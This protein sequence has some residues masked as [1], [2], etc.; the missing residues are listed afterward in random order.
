MDERKYQ[1]KKEKQ[2]CGIRKKFAAKF[3]TPSH[4]VVEYTSEQIRN[5]VDDRQCPLGYG[6]M[7]NLD[8]DGGPD[9]AHNT[10]QVFEGHVRASTQES[11]SATPF[12]WSESE[13][14]SPLE[15]SVERRLLNILHAGLSF[16]GNTKAIDMTD[17]RKGYYDLQELKN[18]LE[19]R[20]AHWD[21]DDSHADHIPQQSAHSGQLNQ[22]AELMAEERSTGSLDAV[23]PANLPSNC[24][25]FLHRQ[26]PLGNTSRR[27]QSFRGGGGTVSLYT[28]YEG[29]QTEQLH[30]DLEIEAENMEAD[31]EF[32]RKLDEAFHEIM[33]S[34]SKRLEPTKERIEAQ[35]S[36]SQSSLNMGDEPWRSLPITDLLQRE[37]LPTLLYDQLGFDIPCLSPNPMDC[38]DMEEFAGEP[39]NLCNL[40]DMPLQETQGTNHTRSNLPKEL[41]L[42]TTLTDTEVERLP[43]GF[44]RPN[45]LY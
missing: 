29:H 7:S 15:G 38:S 36:T 40:V 3:A 42:S 14:R 17:L 11:R 27:S 45:K 4:T 22:I 24:S 9:A 37:H 30:A 39:D 6:D 8:R 2:P 26:S 23:N 41:L 19:L 20:K 21:L 43:S 1:Q 25:N 35:L 33:S 28:P 10:T 32:F 13:P 18:L 34:G 5:K 31:K 12:I 44:W 16:E